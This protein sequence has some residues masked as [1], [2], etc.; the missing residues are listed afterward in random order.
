MSFL[1]TMRPP[2]ALLSLV[3]FTILAVLANYFLLNSE[4]IPD[5]LEIA[6]VSMLVL[7]PT[8]INGIVL[9]VHERARDDSVPPTTGISSR[10]VDELISWIS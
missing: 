8:I 6:V 5:L 10:V 2:R 7:G 3:V 1:F 9:M 4:A